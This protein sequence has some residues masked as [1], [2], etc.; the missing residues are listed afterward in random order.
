MCEEVLD[1]RQGGEFEIG[2]VN[3]GAQTD[4]LSDFIQGKSWMN[5]EQDTQRRYP[6]PKEMGYQDSSEVRRS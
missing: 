2:Q 5:S 3:T 4:K 6:H 1:G